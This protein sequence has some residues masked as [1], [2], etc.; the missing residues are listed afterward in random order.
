MML[1]RSIDEDYSK[2]DKESEYEVEVEE[3]DNSSSQKNVKR[4]R[5]EVERIRNI[6]N[7]INPFMTKFLPKYK[8]EY[9]FE[10][11]P[12]FFGGNAA[13][14]IEHFFTWLTNKKYLAFKI[15]INE[16]F[17]FADKWILSS[18]INIAFIYY[19]HSRE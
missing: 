16:N 18:S 2:E 8:K 10:K 13:K 15:K 1:A 14:L 11:I 12:L 19:M 17:V 6:I 3:E 4:T 7:I 5:V 9:D